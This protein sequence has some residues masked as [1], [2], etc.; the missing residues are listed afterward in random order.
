MKKIAL[1]FAFCLAIGFAMTSCNQ[2]VPQPQPQSPVY[3]IREGVATD[4]TKTVAKFYQTAKTDTLGVT[5]SN[6]KTTTTTVTKKTP[7]N[8]IIT[9][10][11]PAQQPQVQQPVQQPIVNNTVTNIP[12]WGWLLL[13]IAIG[14]LLLMIRVYFLGRTWRSSQNGTT[15]VNINSAGIDTNTRER[16][17]WRE[18]NFRD[19]ALKIIRRGTEKDKIRSFHLSE[20]PNFFELSARYHKPGKKEIGDKVPE[21]K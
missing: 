19:N 21:G 8:L 15:Q 17:L 4:S 18:Q 1:L 11:S 7:G 5:R 14:I 13:A 16:I 10:L 9:E 12:W 20:D 6:G 3:V 2:Q